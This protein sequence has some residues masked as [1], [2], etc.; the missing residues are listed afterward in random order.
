MFEETLGKASDTLVQSPAGAFLVLVCIAFYLTVRSLR[1]ELKEERES[2]Q[3]TRTAQLDDLRSMQK[4][5]DASD[6]MR[7]E[8][9]KMREDRF[10]QYS[11]R[12]HG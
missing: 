10:R 2:H 6:A 7:E 12:G 8:L 9:A 1:L 3:K 5:A 4:I 11:E